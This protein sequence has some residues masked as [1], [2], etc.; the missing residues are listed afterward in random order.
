MILGYVFPDFVNAAVEND[1]SLALASLDA[2]KTFVRRASGRE[3][4]VH[5][6]LN[7]GMNRTGFNVSHGIIPDDLKETVEILKQNP[8]IR[9]EGLFRTLPR[10]KIIPIFQISSLN[11]IQ[12]AKSISKKTELRPK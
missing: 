11:V 4:K 9:V 2:A 12:W 6:K 1:V 7:T 8:N 10:L 5:I 3:L